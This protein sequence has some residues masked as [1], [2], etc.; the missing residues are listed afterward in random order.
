MTK[1]KKKKIIFKINGA[2]DF[3]IDDVVIAI[4]K[5]YYAIHKKGVNINIYPE[6]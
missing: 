4:P 6:Y 5:P 2:I 1:S 3:S